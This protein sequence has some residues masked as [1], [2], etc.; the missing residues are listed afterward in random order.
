[1][2]KKRNALLGIDKVTPMS[3]LK[4]SGIIFC[5][6]TVILIVS[7]IVTEEI[8]WTVLSGY[9]TVL[10]GIFSFLS[11]LLI[12]HTITFQTTTFEHTQFETRIFELIR[13]HRDNVA[14][15]KLKAFNSTEEKYYD[16]H[17]AYRE[18]HKQIWK[19]YRAVEK[20]VYN[21]T[22]DQI[23]LDEQQVRK[24]EELIKKY[25]KT[26]LSLH[27]LVHIDIAYLIVFYGLH[28][29]GQRYLKEKISKKYTSEFYE[30]IF[31]KLGEEIAYWDLDP[32]KPNGI[33]TKY[34]GGHQYRLGHY[35]RHIYQ[36]VK[37]IDSNQ[38]LNYGERYKYA[39]M[40][41][42]QM[43]TFEQSL[44][45]FNSISQLG[46]PW[47]LEAKKE[48]ELLLTKYDLVRNIPNEIY[49]GLNIKD[50]YPNLIF[51]GED[52]NDN[53]NRLILNKIFETS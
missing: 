49:T 28:D 43:S 17:K 13:Y 24:D 20:F 1:M 21:K 25:G 7:C 9:G 32:K 40:L 35:F 52:E 5:A 27:K 18:I 15:C 23:Y 14:A 4:A 26:N 42:A 36:T 19:A 11:I 46:R 33:N 22:A 39:T 31:K 51:D 53:P 3:V 29:E 37:Y 16:G 41:R 47:E 44:L 45:F 38:N 10:A 34:Y 50:V 48:N 2:S 6:F 8:N 12:Y 30:P